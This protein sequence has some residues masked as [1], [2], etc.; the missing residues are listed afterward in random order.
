M[1]NNI[2]GKVVV[3][4]GLL[5]KAYFKRAAVT[6]TTDGNLFNTV[7][8][9]MSTHGNSRPHLKPGTARLLKASAL[10]TG[11]GIA[12]YLIASRSN[13]PKSLS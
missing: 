11:I 5:M 8:F 2:A 9:A 1:E 3:I 13:R 6:E 7:N 10:L 12:V 4:T